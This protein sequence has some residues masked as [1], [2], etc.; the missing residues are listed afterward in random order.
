MKKNLDLPKNLYTNGKY[1]YYKNPRTGRKIN[2]NCS[3]SEAIELAKAAN[4][5][6]QKVPALILRDDYVPD[7]I[8]RFERE[9]LPEHEYAAST[10]AEITIKLKQYRSEFDSNLS[11]L[12]VQTLSAWLD[13]L[14]H[15]AY[16]KHRALWINI[17]R[18]AMSKG[19]THFNAAEATL[20]KRPLKRTRDRLSLD[21]YKAIYSTADPWFQIA[22]DAALYTLQRRSDLVRIKL[23]DFEDDTLPI[24]Q[25]KT[26]TALRIKANEGLRSVIRRATWSGVASPFLIHKKPVRRRREYLDRKE[27]YTQVT[28]EMLSR[29]FARLRDRVTE[30]TATFHE[31]RSLG[32]RLLIEQGYSDEFVQVLMGHASMKMTEHY[33]EDG[34]I[35]WIQAEAGLSLPNLYP[36]FTQTDSK[37]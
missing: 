30:T 33:L 20:P 31:I 37:K 1:F 12:D 36:K 11:G 28:P 35:E 26:C 14:E 29:E 24:I 23:A 27:H 9:F 2:L 15:S 3:R 19:L 10:L 18:F 7:I 13:R 8:D 4:H 5:E 21:D 32:G 34:K 16:I 17:Y 25:Q 22:M 6:L